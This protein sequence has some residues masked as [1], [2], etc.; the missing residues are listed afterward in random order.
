[1]DDD[2]QLHAQPSN[3]PITSLRSLFYSFLLFFHYLT[4]AGGQGDRLIGGG[5]GGVLCP[6]HYFPIIL[7]SIYYYFF[8]I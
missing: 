7:C 3:C 5:G 2:P 8:I 4:Y 1:M 6:P